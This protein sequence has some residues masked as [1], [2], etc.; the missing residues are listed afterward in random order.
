[1][2]KNMQIIK[3]KSNTRLMVYSKAQKKRLISGKMNSGCE[4]CKK[5]I[6]TLR[7]TCWQFLKLHFSAPKMSDFLI[8]N[9]GGQLTRT[10]QLIDYDGLMI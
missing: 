1:M 5:N 10:E 3:Q 4:D 2:L 6:L 7:T 8:L 9:W